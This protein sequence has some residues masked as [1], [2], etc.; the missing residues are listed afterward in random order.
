MSILFVCEG[1]KRPKFKSREVSQWLNYIISK[2]NQLPGDLTVIFCDDSYLIE[3]NRNFLSHD[4]FTDII[5]FDYTSENIVS[6]DMYISVERVYDNSDIFQVPKEIELLRVI[7]HGL[8]HLLGFE[9]KSDKGKKIIREL[10]NNALALF[11][12]KNYGC[13][14]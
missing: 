13:F 4:F 9:D 12:D 3:L 11:R 5:T 10:E 14:K 1:V 7:V 8:F 2:Y 6:G